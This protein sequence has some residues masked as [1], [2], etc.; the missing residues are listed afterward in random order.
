LGALWEIETRK[1]DRNEIS[2]KTTVTRRAVSPN[3][4]T[5]A[6]SRLPE[7]DDST[8]A[9]SIISDTRLVNCPTISIG[10]DE[11]TFGLVHS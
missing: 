7:P 11:S 1:S 9:W 4:Q 8:P 5:E 2:P 6:P 3:P 10:A